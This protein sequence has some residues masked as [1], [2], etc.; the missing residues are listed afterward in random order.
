[1]P[2]YIISKITMPAL[3]FLIVLFYAH[4]KYTFSRTKYKSKIYQ[5]IIMH[6]LIMTLNK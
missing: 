3:L 6:F 5:A 4:V 1:M 2:L